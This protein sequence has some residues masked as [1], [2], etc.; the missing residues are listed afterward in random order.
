M[1]AMTVKD[2]SDGRAT[3]AFRNLVTELWYACSSPLAMPKRFN[4]I[5]SYGTKISF[6]FHF[7]LLH[8]NVCIRICR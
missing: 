8:M 3:Q 7:F 6:Y 4:P 1:G 2:A 5:E